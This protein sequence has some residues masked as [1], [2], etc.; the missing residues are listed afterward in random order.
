MMFQSKWRKGLK[1]SR[2]THMVSTETRNIEWSLWVDAVM[3]NY[4]PHTGYDQNQTIG[5]RF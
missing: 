3:A 4:I 1:L 2:L 5:A